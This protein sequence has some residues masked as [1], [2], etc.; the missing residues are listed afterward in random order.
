MWASSSIEMAMDRRMSSR[1]MPGSP[2]TF[3]SAPMGSAYRP[4]RSS[5]QTPPARN[6]Q[7]LL[8]FG[9]HAIGSGVSPHS[10]A[11]YF[12]FGKQAFRATGRS[13]AAVCAWFSNLPHPEPMTMSRAR[14]VPREQWW[15]ILRE[16]HAE[17]IPGR[18]LVEHTG[19]DRLHV[20][21][22][23]EIL[24]NV[25]SWRAV[26]AISPISPAPLPPTNACAGHEWRKWLPMPRR[27]TG[28][29]RPGRWQRRS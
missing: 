15:Q 9:G 24:P 4:F 28:T 6:T 13:R 27:R 19:A 25:P 10:D 8:G 7:A 1:T 20:M 22:A 26:C 16:A 3:S 12:V 18:V 23:G 2:E 21:G 14:E 29:R 5:T 11:M 17:D